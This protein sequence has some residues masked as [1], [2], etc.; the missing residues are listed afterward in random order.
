MSPE[1]IIEFWR[2]AGERMWFTKDAAFDG[3]LSVRFKDAL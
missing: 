2:I 3:V 1:G